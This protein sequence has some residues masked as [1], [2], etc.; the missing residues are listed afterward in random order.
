MKIDISDQQTL[1]QASAILYAGVFNTGDISYDEAAKTVTLT[2]WR[3]LWEETTSERKLLF[4]HLWKAPHMR[5][6]LKFERVLGLE[7]EIS[8]KLDWYSVERLRFDPLK[9]ELHLIG[10][11]CI[12][13]KMKVESL[14]GK[15]W[16]LDERTNENFG[17][18]TISLKSNRGQSHT[19]HD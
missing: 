6:M 9:G 3:E 11:C 14:Q 16:D 17:K 10:S 18:R 2:L 7:L 4:F 1:E 8:D 15:L 13:I 19:A 12:T 5:C